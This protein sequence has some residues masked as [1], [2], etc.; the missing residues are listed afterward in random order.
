MVTLKKAAPAFAFLVI[1][2]TLA[3]SQRTLAQD[4]AKNG[5]VTPQDL[6]AP[7]PT[8]WLS[9]LA[10]PNATPLVRRV[11]AARTLPNDRGELVFAPIDR[12]AL[13][14]LNFLEF[15][16][17]DDI[18]WTDTINRRHAWAGRGATRRTRIML[19]ATGSQAILILPSAASSDAVALVRPGENG[20]LDTVAHQTDRIPTA[21]DAKD[22]AA[23]LRDLFGY[24][25]VVLAHEGPYVLA[26][27]PDLSHS[28]K[29][30]SAV[31]VGNSAKKFSLRKD[32]NDPVA[33]LRLARSSGHYSVWRVVSSTASGPL[34]VATKLHLESRA[35]GGKQ[36][37]GKPEAPLL[38]G[39]Q[40]DPVKPDP[41]KQEAPQ[42]NDPQ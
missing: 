19:Q 22:L 8:E 5:T 42:L 27:S 24:D 9:R 17:P 36:A 12:S 40:L 1:S 7:D 38:E 21:E 14:E 33:F 41:A 20:N 34:P 18:A 3:F 28:G 31:A 10:L 25:A 23:A 29:L 26:Q 37:T 6:S 13:Q 30:I 35:R 4:K 2:A 16:S 11:I 15:A 32:A 39:P